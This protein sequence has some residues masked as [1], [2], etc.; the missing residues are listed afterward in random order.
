MT[1][2]EIVSAVLQG[3]TSQFGRLVD[4]YLPLVRGV[5]ASQFRDPATVDDLTQDAFITVF[6]N[7]NKLRNAAKFSPWLTGIARNTCRTHRRT[8]A[9]QTRLKTEY[10]AAP[11]P[12]VATPE[13]LAQRRELYAWV[14]SQIGS[15]PGKTREAMVLH[16]VEGLSVG[17]VA[18]QS[19]VREGAVKK[20]LQY[21]RQLVG[22]ALWNE[23][24]EKTAEKS[25][26]ANRTR[27]RI[28]KALPLA[29]APW[30]ARGAE[31]ATGS[32]LAALLGSSTLMKTGVAVLCIAAL[33]EGYLWFQWD[34]PDRGGAANSQTE[35]VTAGA[36]DGPP[37]QTAPN[38]SS[39]A[40]AFAANVS[41]EEAG[42]L[43]VN[44][45]FKTIERKQLDSSA[46][47]KGLHPQQNQAQTVDSGVPVPEVIVRL[48]PTGVDAEGMVRYFSQTGVAPDEQTAAMNVFRT[49]MELRGKQM[50]GPATEDARA[51]MDQVLADNKITMPRFQEVMEK[52]NTAMMAETGSRDGMSALMYKLAPRDQWLEAVTDASGAVRFNDVPQGRCIVVAWDTQAKKEFPPDD[53]LDLQILNRTASG[54]DEISFGGVAMDKT[55]LIDDLRSAVRGQVVD[56]ST[57]EPISGA[58]VSVA[59]IDAPGDEQSQHTGDDGT[60]KVGVEKFAPGPLHVRVAAKDH[61]P[62]EFSHEREFGVVSEEHRVAL[63]PQATVCGQITMADGRP[64]PDISVLRWEGDSG[65][66]VATTD[67]EGRFCFGHTGGTITISASQGATGSDRRSISLRADESGALDLVLPPVGSI[68]MFVLNPSGEPVTALTYLR[69]Y[70]LTEGRPQYYFPTREADDGH[71]ELAYLVPDAYR[72]EAR[73]DGLEP[74][75]L[76]NINVLPG[77]AAGPY[78]IQLK[79]GNPDLTVRFE[80]ALGKP[81]QFYYFTLHR[82]IDYSSADGSSHGSFRD[83]TANP[84]T[85]AKG[86]Y[87]FT[88]L[89]PGTYEVGAMGQSVEIEAPYMGV[90]TIKDKPEEPSE[91]QPPTLYIEAAPYR[92]EN[93]QR[94]PVHADQTSI[95]MTPLDKPAPQVSMYGTVDAPGRYLITFIQRDGGASAFKEVTFTEDDLERNKGQQ[96]LMEIEVP[97][98]GEVTGAAYEADG[99]PMAGEELGV[100]P[101]ELHDLGA[102]TNFEHYVWRQLAGDLAHHVSTDASG[103]FTLDGLPPGVY[104]VGTMHG[105]FSQP[106]EVASGQT[107]GPVAIIAHDE[108]E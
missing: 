103:A 75:L 97:Q 21:G 36:A 83:M 86:E 28:L 62:Q 70:S 87:V 48:I 16:Y 53:E 71:Y 12:H 29:A 23:L 3:D 15:L 64:A 6:R 13:E 14:H 49:M 90:L 10:A 68:E 65:N 102:A 43:T 7:L 99:T 25:A 95:Y 108:G 81:H 33:V 80:D 46:A 107:T 73:V 91:P 11:T 20:R 101:V 5:C 92:I 78:H 93:G 79:A 24:G 9:R 41:S 42:V 104:I 30:L 37:S 40:G 4:R 105:D 2:T 54:M 57:G 35:S 34:G 32:G 67:A 52:V 44:V 56:A 8:L 59:A 17:Q 89:I 39:A 60:F 98:G 38:Q 74:I 61:A 19:G 94:V 55:L 63:D 45:H 85:D 76:D 22:D 51:L 1:D 96:L 69:L 82:L 66:G 27:E 26:D 84:R 72:L 50:S 31:A 100:L 58:N 47:E 106:V 18:H 77:H 88:G